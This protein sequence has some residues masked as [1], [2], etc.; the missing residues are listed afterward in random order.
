MRCL[1][2]SKSHDPE[3]LFVFLFLF[4]ENAW[5]TFSVITSECAGTSWHSAVAAA[6]T[7]LTMLKPANGCGLWVCGAV[8]SFYGIICREES[9]QFLA[10]IEIEL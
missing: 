7:E 5:L 6:T 10:D 1:F 2:I 9:E 4:F 3:H 8:I